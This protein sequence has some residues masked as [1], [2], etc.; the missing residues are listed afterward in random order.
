M[1][2]S[3][4][5]ALNTIAE[6]LKRIRQKDP[7][8]LVI[9]SFDNDFQAHFKGGYGAAFG[10]PLTFS[11]AAA[12]FCGPALHQM[13]FLT[14]GA[15]MTLPDLGYCNYLILIGSQTGFGAGLATIKETMEMA[16]ARMR[17]MK[18]VVIDPVMTAAAAKADE[19]LPI[20]PGTDAALA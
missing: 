1:E 14:Q 17:G 4:E 5:E 7:K 12:Y 10:T 18:L 19:W 2:I 3:W 6:K 11:G 20:R 13:V 8:K 15:F 16:D 9:M